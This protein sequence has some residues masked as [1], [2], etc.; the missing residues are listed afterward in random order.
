MLRLTAYAWVLVLERR[1]LHY[2]T[3]FL[4]KVGFNKMAY[5]FT[6]INVN[7]LTTTLTD[8]TSPV[9]GVR[10]EATAVTTPVMRDNPSAS[11]T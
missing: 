2:L 1:V 4:T 11:A 9:M 3:A 8:K 10:H 7:M 5:L 6:W